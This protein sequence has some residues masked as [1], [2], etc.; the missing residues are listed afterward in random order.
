MYNK[1]VESAEYIKSKI[2]IVP[3]IG[4][5][6]G[7]GL[8]DLAQEIENSVV[9]DY[10][11]IPNF[12]VS[13]VEGH[14]GKLHIGTLMGK[15]VVAMQGRFHFYEGYSM[16]DVTLPVRVMKLIGVETLVVTN[17][18][19][20][21]NHDFNPGTLMIIND[22][23][24]LT[25]GNPLIGKNLEQFGPRFPDMSRA[26][27]PELSALAKQVAADL[28]IEVKEGVYTAIS[29]PNYLSKAE[30]R[31]LMTIGS[32]AVGM[33]TVPETI[34]ANHSGMKVLG[35]SCVTD[36]AIPDTLVPLEHAQVME[37]ANQ[38]KPKFIKL[39]KGI[40]KEV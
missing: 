3:E 25:G 5:I 2:D 28:E 27:N 15:K 33:S 32:D 24:N 14:Q 13:T 17:A 38:T 34:V 18:C 10:S 11:D 4:I 39:V 35:I 22:H 29:G 7:S 26:Y 31:M 37:I 20:G 16:Q 8:G 1:L 19:G 40:L 30:L 23:I 36:M 9:I 12:P 6:L 21:L